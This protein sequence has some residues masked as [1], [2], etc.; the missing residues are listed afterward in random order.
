MHLG[1]IPFSIYSTLAPDQIRYLFGNA[2]SKIVITDKLSC[3]LSR[4][5]GL[6]SLT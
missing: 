6:T 1:A 5:P 4:P 3:P 2:E